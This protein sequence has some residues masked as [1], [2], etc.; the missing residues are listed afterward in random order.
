MVRV[1]PDMVFS[2]VLDALETVYGQ[3]TLFEY[4]DQGG[5]VVTVDEALKW[6][7]FAAMADDRSAPHRQPHTRGRKLSAAASA[8]ERRLVSC[9]GVVPS[10]HQQ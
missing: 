1:L 10:L 3:K 5:R 4:Q 8:T 2:D 9:G 7:R 6:D